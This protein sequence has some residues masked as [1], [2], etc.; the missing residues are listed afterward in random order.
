MLS[1]WRHFCCVYFYLS[2]FKKGGNPYNLY[3]LL[4]DFFY[5]TTYE[6]FSMAINNTLHRFY[7][8]HNS[9]IYRETQIYWPSSLSVQPWKD[10]LK[11]RSFSK[12]FVLRM[13]WLKRIINSLERAKTK[14]ASSC[15][16]QINIV[17]YRTF[18]IGKIV[19]QILGGRE[20]TERQR[21]YTKEL[22]LHWKTD[23]LP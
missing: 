20:M 4:L 1:F 18:T 9:P 15:I 16:H 6:H 19:F 11:R 8:L 23:W 21:N 13:S 14:G 10:V 2:L 12:S 7:W 22:S 5:S 17:I 3:G